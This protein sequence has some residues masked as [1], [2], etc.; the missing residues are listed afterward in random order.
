MLVRLGD[1]GFHLGRNFGALDEL[2]REID[3]V[4][5]GHDPYAGVLAQ[6]TLA[7]VEFCDEG[8]AFVLE[9]E[10]PG[11][12]KDEIQVSLEEETL[13]IRGEPRAA[14]ATAEA[15]KR[16][17]PRASFARS[18]TLPVRVDAEKVTATLRNGIL[19]LRLPKA[20]E[21]KPRQIAVRA[22]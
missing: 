5:D 3:R 20:A 4:F 8:D 18:F 1:V 22:A 14:E 2:R 21:A 9:A 10:V 19:E 16:S 11:F 17:R 12:E 13:T 6:R 7:R 15:P